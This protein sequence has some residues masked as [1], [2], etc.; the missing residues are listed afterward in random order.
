MLTVDE[1][2]SSQYADGLAAQLSQLGL[3]IK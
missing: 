2:D 1:D 3:V